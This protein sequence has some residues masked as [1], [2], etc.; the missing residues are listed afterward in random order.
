MS[1]C[2]FASKL[3]GKGLDFFH[4]ITDENVIEFQNK[5]NDD[6]HY[7]DKTSRRILFVN[8]IYEEW[9]FFWENYQ[10]LNHIDD[11]VRDDIYDAK[12]NKLYFEA[13]G[14]FLQKKEYF[15]DNNFILN[16]ISKSDNLIFNIER[17]IN[18]I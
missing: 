10:K 8:I 5:H 9:Y 7:D 16:R 17:Y 4:S 11:S 6:C 14:K 13:S 3:T 18:Q 1:T 12:Y 2:P 15:V